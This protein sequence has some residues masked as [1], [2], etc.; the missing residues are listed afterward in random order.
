MLPAKIRGFRSKAINALI[1]CVRAQRPIA[2]SGL[3]LQH[4][5]NG[6]II[7]ADASAKTSKE[8]PFRCSLITTAFQKDSTTYALRIQQGALYEVLDD[9]ASEQPLTLENITQDEADPNAWRAENLTSGA[10]FIRKDPAAYTLAFGEPTN[11][12][13]IIATITLSSSSSKPKLTQRALGDLY[14]FN[15]QPPEQPP[16]AWEVRKNGDTWQIYSPYWVYASSGSAPGAYA[17]GMESGWNTLEDKLQGG[18]LYALLTHTEAS[19]EGSSATPESIVIS[20][21]NT[22]PSPLF[23][24]GIYNIAVPI[25]KFTSTTAEDGTQT[26][27]WTQLHLGIITETIPLKGDPGEPGDPGEDG[28]DGATYIPSQRS[29]S[30]IG[31]YLDFKNSETGNILRGVFN[32][33]GPYFIP[34]LREVAGTD[35]GVYLDFKKSE[36]N[37][38]IEGSVDLRGPQGE[39]GTQGEQGPAGADGKDGEPGK[40]GEDGATYTPSLRTETGTGGGVYLDFTNSK[41]N[42]TIEGSVNLKGP[43]GD[44]GPQGPQG[45]QGP[46]GPK[47]P[48]GDT[49]PQG[50]QG[51]AGTFTGNPLSI[52]VVTGV[53]YDKYSH[54][55]TYTKQTI[56]FYGTSTGTESTVNITTATAHSDEHK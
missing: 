43:K 2:G 35:G 44:T 55:L 1:D 37:E 45:E 18:N 52:T 30:D 38:L 4:T 41:T 16:L 19:G 20:I 28:K 36:T 6:T 27:A 26:T 23:S 33:R 8:G 53:K 40:A 47:G 25:G 29:G 14:L 34:S 48:K 54:E 12:L 22:L 49:G 11:A 10:L 15:S 50:P 32:L 51:P 9:I 13:F 5:P 3:R 21:V 46:V 7:S 17:E 39:Q 42:T 24:N 31:V 56:Y